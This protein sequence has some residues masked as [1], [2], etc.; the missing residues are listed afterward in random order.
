MNYY[1]RYMGDY[2][3]DTGHLSLTEHGVYTVLL[4]HYYSKRCPLPARLDSLY[5]LC[6]ATTK[7]EQ[8]AVKAVAVEFFQRAADG[9]RHNQRA[10]REIAEWERLAQINRERGKLGGRP[11]RNPDV[12][13]G[14][15]PAGSIPETREVIFKQPSPT[16]TP[17]PTPAPEPEPEP[18]PGSGVLVED[19]SDS[20]PL[21]KRPVP[22]SFHEEVIAVYHEILPELPRVK[23]WSTKRRQAL[24]ARIRERCKDGKPAQSIHYWREFF[25]HVAASDFLAGRKTEFRADLEWLIR[26]E[27]FAKVIEGKY[28]NRDR[29]NGGAH[30]R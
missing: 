18:Q 17:T 23:V 24:D 15:N 1:R 20:R 13:P 29:G 16:P 12:N 3:R 10:D 5:R 7:H 25:S 6:R 27:N 19:S 22:S 4:D 26:P 8:D 2:Q 9:R 28:V 30:A 14:A 11:K 21:R